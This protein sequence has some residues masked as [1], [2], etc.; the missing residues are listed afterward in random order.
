MYGVTWT[1]RVHLKSDATSSC[2]WWSWAKIQINKDTLGC[3]LNLRY[4]VSD[5]MGS[6][7]LKACVCLVHCICSGCSENFANGL[8][9]QWWQ[10]TMSSVWC[11]TAPQA[12]RRSIRLWSGETMLF[13]GMAGVLDLMALVVTL[14]AASVVS[15][16]TMLGVSR[17]ADSSSCC[18]VIA[19]SVLRPA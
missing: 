7:W 15:L 5:D 13:E 10:V 19:D 4:V 16:F 8:L 11:A 2:W 1:P 14:C 18:L 17:W 6:A 3:G 12:G 9:P